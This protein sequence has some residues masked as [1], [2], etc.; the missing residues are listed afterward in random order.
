MRA[1]EDRAL[2]RIIRYGIPD[3][4]ALRAALSPSTPEDKP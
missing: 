4:D 1:A 3:P 2:Y